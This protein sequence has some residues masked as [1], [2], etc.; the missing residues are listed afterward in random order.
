MTSLKFS[1]ECPSGKPQD[2]APRDLGRDIQHIRKQAP[3][4]PALAPWVAGPGAHG[5]WAPGGTW[6]LQGVDGTA[7]TSQDT[8]FPDIQDASTMCAT[9]SPLCPTPSLQE[10]HID[11]ASACPQKTEGN[12]KD[13]DWMLGLLGLNS[14]HTRCFASTCQNS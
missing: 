5:L 1:A 10:D 14:S 8:S 13:S 7:L 6:K 9:T 2:E 4:T 11:I 12:Y 3:G